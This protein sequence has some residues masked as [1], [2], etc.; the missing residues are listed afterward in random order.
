[1]RISCKCYTGIKGIL[2]LRVTNEYRVTNADS[3]CPASDPHCRVGAIIEITVALW[4]KSN[5]C[6]L[7]AG[8]VGDDRGGCNSAS[9]AGE[10][11][12]PSLRPFNICS[13]INLFLIFSFDKLNKPRVAKAGKVNK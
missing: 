7:G 1:M 4:I 2:H 5:L 11:G 10:G 9:D 13:N 6:P 3:F 12:F 8:N